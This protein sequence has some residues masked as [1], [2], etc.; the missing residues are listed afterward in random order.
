MESEDFLGYSMKKPGKRRVKAGRSGFD[1][2]DSHIVFGA[3]TGRVA[4]RKLKDIKG[5][6]RKSHR[7][8]NPARISRF[9]VFN[10]HDLW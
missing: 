6:G 8:R 10:H 3:K 7:T 1:L 5:L 4:T 9:S 2:F